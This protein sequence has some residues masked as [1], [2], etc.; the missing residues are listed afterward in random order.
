MGTGAAWDI[1]APTDRTI[2]RTIHRTIHRTIYRTIYRTIL[3]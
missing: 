3:F 2:Y 1:Q